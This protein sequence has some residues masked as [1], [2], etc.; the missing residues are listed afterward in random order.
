MLCGFYRYS[1]IKRTHAH[2]G[3]CKVLSNRHVS[4]WNEFLDGLVSDEELIAH[5]K[6]KSSL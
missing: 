2:G 6:A 3:V 5:I 4:A 1:N